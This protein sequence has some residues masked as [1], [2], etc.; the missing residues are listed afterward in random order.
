M[1]TAVAHFPLRQLGLLVISAVSSQW[2]IQ[3][4]VKRGPS[5]SCSSPLPLSPPFLPL[6]L[7]SFPLLTSRTP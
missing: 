1:G 7:L 6:P 2:H 4:F 5:V 3:E